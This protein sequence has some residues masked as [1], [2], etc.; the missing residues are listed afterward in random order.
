MPFNPLKIRLN[1][2]VSVSDEERERFLEFVSSQLL[3]IGCDRAWREGSQVHFS[4]NLFSFKRGRYHVM[5]GVNGGVIAFAPSNQMTYEFRITTLGIIVL[6]FAAFALLILALNPETPR[7]IPLFF[8]GVLAIVMAI[9]R[10]VIRY[11]QNTFFQQLQPEYE[12]MKSVFVK[13]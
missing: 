5:A 12:R 1:C 13:N 2:Y 8:I 10:A 4:N 9:N 7:F 11:R 6:V 3:M